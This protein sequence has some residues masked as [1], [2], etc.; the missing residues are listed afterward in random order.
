MEYEGSAV[1]FQVIRHKIDSALTP[2][3]FLKF[4]ALAPNLPINLID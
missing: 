2:A 1:T 3:V 4:Q